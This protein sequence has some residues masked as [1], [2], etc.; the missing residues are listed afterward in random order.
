MCKQASTCSSLDNIKNPLSILTDKLLGVI[1]CSEPTLKPLSMRTNSRNDP[2]GVEVARALFGTCDGNG[3][4]SEV[5]LKP[6]DEQKTI[7]WSCCTNCAPKMIRN[8]TGDGK[9]RIT[10]DE[11]SMFAMIGRF[12]LPA[13]KELNSHIIIANFCENCQPT[14]KPEAKLKKRTKSPYAIS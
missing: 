3:L 1:I 8:R 5:S 11:A 7:M 12:N 13:E 6:Q 10:K 2:K 4:T 14:P 9:Y